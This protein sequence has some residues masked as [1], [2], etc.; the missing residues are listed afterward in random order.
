MKRWIAGLA[1][2]ATLGGAAA[3]GDPVESEITPIEFDGTVR[4]Y[5]LPGPSSWLIE[6]MDDPSIAYYPTNLPAEYHVEGAQL[7]IQ[8]ALV[9]DEIIYDRNL[10]EIITVT[11]IS[12]P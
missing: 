4:E 10:I 8:A 12:L 3:C 7:N 2:A 6:R 9:H 5:P 11:V 1:L